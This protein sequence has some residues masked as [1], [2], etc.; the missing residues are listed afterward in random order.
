VLKQLD[1]MHPHLSALKT[2][3]DEITVVMMSINKNSDRRVADSING[4]GGSYPLK[5]KT[6]AFS[7]DATCSSHPS[8]TA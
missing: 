3:K 4:A 7:P 5:A 1:H 6:A 8:L 2:D